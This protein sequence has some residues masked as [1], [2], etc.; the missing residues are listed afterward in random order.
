M[1]GFNVA[2][3][4]KG[5][6]AL[7]T[8]DGFKR[9]IQ[10]LNINSIR[11]AGLIPT[12]STEPSRESL[13]TSFEGLIVSSSQTALGDVTFLIPRDYDEGVDK[14]DLRFLVNSGGDT[15]T[16]TID[17]AMYR[18]RAGAA[19]SSDIDPTISAAVN[20]N[21]AK[22]GY[23][24]VRSHGDGWKA[25][26]AVTCVFTTSAHTTDDFHVYGFEAVYASDLAY[27][28]DDERS[29]SDE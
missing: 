20:N 26:D 15:N 23:V 5:L 17:C 21:T 22:A 3:F 19:L 16:P 10:G 13:E 12:A 11:V 1:N 2:N 25:G 18:K 29:I 8:G 4:L 6:E 14:L 7:V 9:V 28:E 27:Y 24:E